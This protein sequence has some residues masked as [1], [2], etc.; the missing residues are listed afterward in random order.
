MSAKREKLFAH[1]RRTIAVTLATGDVV[2]ARPLSLA[3][4][5]RVVK[6]CT[7]DG[8]VQT[9]KLIPAIVIAC[10]HDPDSDEPL[11]TLGDRDAIGAM[12]AEVVD[13]MW[14]AAAELN[15]LGADAAK[16]AEKN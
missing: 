7:E 6:E 11:F 13:P 1:P 12:P 10:I 2:E 16:D 14:T 5:A 3:Q 15:G 9:D 8:E 4:R